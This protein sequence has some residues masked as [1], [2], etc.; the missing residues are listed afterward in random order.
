MVFLHMPGFLETVLL[1]LLIALPFFSGQ[2]FD[3][4]AKRASTRSHRSFDLDLSLTMSIHNEVSS[5]SF[6]FDREKGEEEKRRKKRGRGEV[7]ENCSERGG[8]DSSPREEG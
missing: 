3:E 7:A 8:Q 5:L 4:L 6:P 1:L 2:N